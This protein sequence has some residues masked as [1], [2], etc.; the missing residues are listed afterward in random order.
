ML[1]SFLLAIERVLRLEGFGGRDSVVVGVGAGDCV[2]KKGCERVLGLLCVEEGEEERG[3]VWRWEGRR[4]NWK[5][6]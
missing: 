2:G 5:F 4:C 3:C 6:R 1:C